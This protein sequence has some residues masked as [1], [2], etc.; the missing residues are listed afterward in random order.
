MTIK[1]ANKRISLGYASLGICITYATI[2]SA[3]GILES[4]SFWIDELYT[5]LFTTGDWDSFWLEFILPDTHPPLYFAV[6][7]IWSQTFGLSEISL[8]SLSFGFSLITIFAI[9]YRWLKTRRISFIVMM[10]LVVSSP[11]FLYYSQEARSYSA[12]IL[13]STC[14]FL[15]ASEQ[16]QKKCANKTISTNVIFCLLCIGNSLV[17]YFGLIFSCVILLIEVFENKI[18]EH[19]RITAM[20]FAGTL[21]WPFF[22][23]G[24][25][26]EIGQAQTTKIAL[27][28]QEWWYPL[29][30]YSI[31]NLPF[32]N[33][34]RSIF[35]WL[36]GTTLAIGTVI[37]IAASTT[38]ER[39]QKELLQRSTFK[40]CV[41]VLVI[42]LFLLL[43]ANSISPISTYRNYVVFVAPTTMLISIACEKFLTD[44]TLL[45]RTKA[46]KYATLVA[47]TSGLVLSI[48]ISSLNL[49]QK[50]FNNRNYKD[51]ANYIRVNN[52]CPEVC[53]TTDF[54]PEEDTINL[55]GYYFKGIPLRGLP[56]TIGNSLPDNYSS[57]PFPLIGSGHTDKEIEE[58]ASKHGYSKLEIISRRN[59]IYPKKAFILTH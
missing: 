57:T 11:S 36:F 47:L 45:P 49:D 33:S 14:L 32:I 44:D 51:L 48:K 29:H 26:G 17:H 22:H 58:L 55:M 56:T 46:A 40:Y 24:I 41:S 50:A 3:S 4:Y 9:W 19:R 52:S 10:L 59:N 1:A 6:A 38:N 28:N 18:F 31:T 23:L 15:N 21:A 42:S 12:L 30:A 43:L 8:R 37:Y 13:T 2:V 54:D 16:R 5:V 25:V 34:G 53:I 20:C 39:N 7:K 27:T 35:D